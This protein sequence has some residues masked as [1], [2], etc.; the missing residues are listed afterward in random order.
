MT[1]KERMLIALGKGKPDRM[2]VTLHQ[3]QD[4]HLNTY[5]G[6]MSAL[7]A[8]RGLGLDASI[9]HFEPGGQFWLA[10]PAQYAHLSTPNWRDEVEVL[11]PSL[12]HRVLKHRIT[13]PRGVLSYSTESNLKTTWVTEYLIK[14]DEDIHLIRDYMPWPSVDKVEV[15]RLYEDVGDSGILRGFVWGDQAGCWQHACCLMD[16]T[17]MIMRCFD[18]P[19]WVHELLGILLEKKLASIE[20]MDGAPFDLVETGG[21]A[22]S[23]TVIS[24]DL[25]EEFCLPYDRK[26]HDAL[27]ASRFRITYHTCGGTV[28]IEEHI[29]ANGCDAS[30]TMAPKS[31]GGN[32]EPWDLAAKIGG[33]VALIGGIDQF[34]VAT[35]GSPK[36]I[37][38]KVRELF[39]KT[40]QGGGVIC[41]LSDHFFDA[42][43]E[44]LRAYAEAGR[45]CSY[46]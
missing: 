41:S 14:H 9:Q 34:S 5:L 13:T 35:E 38:E 42:P 21:G 40:A 25:H 20:D 23:S 10:D 33:R 24:P 37:Q 39:E 17:E 3:W 7:E 45:A 46:S 30:E 18:Q 27:H 43:V 16:V 36:L 22:A 8:F 31:I 1:S 26:L 28:G 4:Y 29:V 6:G 15:G 44:N 2:P 32:Q 19:D 12:E 11:D